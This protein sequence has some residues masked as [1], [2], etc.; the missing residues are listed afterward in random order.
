LPPTNIYINPPNP[1]FPLSPTTPAKL[2]TIG[3]SN[4]WL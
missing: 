2:P 1:L 3:A 4:K